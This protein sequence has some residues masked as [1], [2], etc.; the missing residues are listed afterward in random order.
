MTNLK[1]AKVLER[2]EHRDSLVANVRKQLSAWNAFSESMDVLPDFYPALQTGRSELL[3]AANPR[4]L[5]EEECKAV[6]KMVRVLIE[7]NQALQHHAQELSIMVQQ[8]ARDSRSTFS[9][10]DKIAQFA[11][12]DVPD[13]IED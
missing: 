2:T 13:E 7:T 8:W 5:S 1:K 4:P 12:F 11:N 9:R 3:V 6:F 10:I